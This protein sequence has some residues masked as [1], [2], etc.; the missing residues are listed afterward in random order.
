MLPRPNGVVTLLTDYGSQDPYVGILKG[1]MLRCSPKVQWVDIT[2]DAPAHDIATGAFLVRTLLGRF[3]SGTV[4]LAIVDPGVGT[5][6][7]LLAVAA[8]DCYWLAPDNGLLGPVLAGNA[9]ID[10]RAIDVEHLGL[11]AESRTFHG[12]DLLGPVA[13]WLATG[14]YGFSALGP[15]VV[16]PV[17]AGDP[18]SGELRVVHVDRFGNLVTNVSAA[19]FAGAQGVRIAGRSVRQ[20][21]TYGEVAPGELLAYVGSFGLVEVARN[22]G[23]AAALLEVG[24]GASVELLPA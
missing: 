13:A 11:H 6:R 5:S 16:D 15:R 2:H 17:T 20:H 3:P 8:H 24:R 18:F 1:A 12:R 9:A 7:R 14:R 19:A 10:V 4:H 23:S 22:G 21:G